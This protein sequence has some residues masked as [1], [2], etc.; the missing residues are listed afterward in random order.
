MDAKRWFSDRLNQWVNL[1]NLPKDELVLE[2]MTERKLFL[3]LEEELI[4]SRL[5]TLKEL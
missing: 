3:L 4:H 5:K 1:K 2:I